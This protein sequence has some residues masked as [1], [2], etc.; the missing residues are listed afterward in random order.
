[1]AATVRLFSHSGLW[2]APS[3]AGSDLAYDSVKH[4]KQPPIGRATLNCT[5]T[6]A[7]TSSETAAPDKTKICFVQVEAGKS[8]YYEIIPPGFPLVEASSNSPIL[9]GQS[10][11]EF[12]PGWR[13]SVKEVA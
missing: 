3:V 1:M 11:F 10:T 2:T 12:G 13:L 4:L 9:S 8:V 7:D 6:T 5:P